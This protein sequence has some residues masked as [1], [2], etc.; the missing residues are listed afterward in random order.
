MVEEIK[1]QYKLKAKDGSTYLSKG[2]T[3][4]EIEDCCEVSEMIWSKESECSCTLS[5]SNPSCECG[6]YLGE[7]NDEVDLRS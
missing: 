7:W 1:I 4:E 6:G 2:Y 3:L 5:E